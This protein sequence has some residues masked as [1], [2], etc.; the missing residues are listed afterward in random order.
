MAKSCVVLIGSVG[1]CHYL[2]LPT[3][4]YY[5]ISMIDCLITQKEQKGAGKHSSIS[6]MQ[7]LE[8]PKLCLL[9]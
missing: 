3:H 5:M 6:I 2:Q 7:Y 1:V 8:V 4:S 9:E